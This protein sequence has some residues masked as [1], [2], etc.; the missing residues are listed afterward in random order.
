MALL[1]EIQQLKETNP[2]NWSRLL[3]FD[4]YKHLQTYLIEAV[5]LL[6][7]KKYSNSTR[8]YWLEN[9]LTDFPV[10]KYCGKTKLTKN[11]DSYDRACS[12]KCA[13]NTQ[14]RK[15][16]IANT[17]LEKYGTITFLGSDIG[18]QAKEK[19][20]I[21]HGVENVFQLESV[22]EKSRQTLLDKTGYVYAM[23]NPDV[24][25]RAKK[26]YQEKTG[27]S[28]QFANPDVRKHITR[29]YSQQIIANRTKRY[30]SFLTNNEVLPNFSLDEFVKLDNVAQY[31]TLLSWHCNK[32][33]KDFSSHLNQNYLTREGKPARCLSCYP[34]DINLGTSQ[35]EKEII[36]F[37]KSIIY[38]EVLEN[39]R[40]IISPYEL[41]IY[42][43]ERKLAIEFDGLYLHSED[44]GNKNAYYHLTKTNMCEEQGI[45]LIHIFENE[46]LYK[47]DI[48]KSR[49]MN[50]LGNYNY[51]V[52]ARKCEIRQVSGQDCKTFLL[53]NHIQGNV[54]SSV[55]IGLYYND[56]LI[57]LMTFGKSRY[58]KKY[59]WELLRFCNKLGYHIPG[60]ASK[61]LRYF[62]KVYKP[63]SL[64]SYADRRWSKGNVY[65]KL[66]F[67]LLHI[68]EPNYWYFRKGS[69]DL[70]SRVKYQKHKLQSMFDNY[71]ENIT[72]PDIMSANGY[73]R[74]F[75]CGN[76]VY[77][78]VYNK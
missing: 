20:L 50:L 41:D 51:T 15:D 25:E 71:D 77:V 38:C 63:N 8:L 45:Q 4:K 7:D 56:E 48:V 5:P 76:L 2:K 33:G 61:L 75:D 30:N 23:Q 49:L 70:E 32:C 46:W 28:H 19:F 78:K 59:E 16:K 24:Q 72:G 13:A 37:V 69:Y 12:K 55:N 36:K 27:Y 42:I 57:S 9:N 60:G 52:Y 62:E 43:P 3:S 58:N 47:Q 39:A 26:T 21:E 29:D 1:E 65:E 22:K 11:V 31:T 14:E 68:A 53:A 66:G 64:L 34:I 35:A 44:I 73:Y 18:K 74:I 17:C 54:N 10:C 67:S 40:N 6:A